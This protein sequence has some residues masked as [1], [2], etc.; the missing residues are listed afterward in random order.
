MEWKTQ[1]FKEPDYNYSADRKAT[2]SSD[3]WSGTLLSI[4]YSVSKAKNEDLYQ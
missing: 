3:S 1:K 2:L 4:P